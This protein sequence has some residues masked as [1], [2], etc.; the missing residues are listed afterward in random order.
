MSVR[1][2][3][4][5]PEGLGAPRGFSHGVLAPAAS[6]L[7]FVAGQIGWDA[8]Q[9]LVPGGFAPQ[10][11]RA[12]DNIRLVVEGAGGRMDEI[13]RLTIYVTDRSLYERDLVEVGAAYRR[14]VGRHF[15]AMALV[16]V[17]ALLEPG[18]LV[19]IEATA[20]LAP[21]IPGNSNP[22]APE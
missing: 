8:E 10:F 18:A 21:T 16:E 5:N 19:E 17:A 3:M 12:L 2:E 14:I 9:R 11:E 6:R 7:L 22:G 15:P 13:C 1:L 4:I 20:A